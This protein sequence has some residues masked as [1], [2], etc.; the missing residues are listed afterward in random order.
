M[1]NRTLADAAE[2]CNNDFSA[3]LSLSPLRDHPEKVDLAEAIEEERARFRLWAA[4]I[5]A[6]AKHHASLDYRLRESERVRSLV[7]SQL[8]LLHGAASQLSDTLQ[9]GWFPTLYLAK[10]ALTKASRQARYK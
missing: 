5:G 4:N 7:F 9:P 2:S 8:D 10:I 3:L 1:D 6:F